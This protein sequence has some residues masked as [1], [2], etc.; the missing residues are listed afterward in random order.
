V[1]VSSQVNSIQTLRAALPPRTFQTIP[2]KPNN[3]DFEENPPLIPVSGT[4]LFFR[5]VHFVPMHGVK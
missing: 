1:T 4:L 3:W 2:Q 5:L